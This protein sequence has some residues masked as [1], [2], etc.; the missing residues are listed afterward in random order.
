MRNILIPGPSVHPFSF[1]HP[2]LNTP[3]GIPGEHQNDQIQVTG[4]LYLV[5]RRSEVEKVYNPLKDLLKK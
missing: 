4:I 5:E 3:K 2:G 1:A